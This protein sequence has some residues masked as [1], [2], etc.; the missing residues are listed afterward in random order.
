MQFDPIQQDE[1]EGSGQFL[2]IGEADFVITDVTEG[3]T[4]S[5]I[6]KLVIEFDAFQG[7]AKGKIKEH[8][9]ANARFK[10][11]GLCKALGDDKVMKRAEEGTISY[12]DLINKSGRFNLDTREYEGKTYLSI[13][14]Y[15]PKEGESEGINDDDLPF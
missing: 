3:Q 1:W 13:S 2:E 14:H 10:I 7:N 9:S 15:L 5:G 8:I 6:P 11:I 12:P 4:A